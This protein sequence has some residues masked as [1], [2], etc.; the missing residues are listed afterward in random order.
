MKLSKILCYISFIVIAVF[1]MPAFAA[2]PIGQLDS[3]DDINDINAPFDPNTRWVDTGTTGLPTGRML[4]APPGEVNEGTGSMK[5]NFTP[6]ILNIHKQIEV[7]R[8]FSPVLDVNYQTQAITLWVWSAEV[9]DSRSQT[10][11][12][13]LQNVVLYDS[14]VGASQHIG[15]FTVPPLKYVG[16]NKVIAPFRN[17]MWTAGKGVG[18]PLIKPG[19]VEWNKITKIGLFVSC[20]PNYLIGNPIYMDNLRLELAP[21]P[22]AR[23]YQIASCDN[24]VNDLWDELRG[25]GVMVQSDA[26]FHEG[27][28]SMMIDF[29]VYG[30]AKPDIC[31]SLYF[32]PA[33]DFTNDYND[34]AITVWL[35]TDKV[36]DSKLKEIILHDAEWN[37][38]RFRVPLTLSPGWNKIV[39]RLDEFLWNRTGNDTTTI[40][41]NEVRK[42]AILSMEIWTECWDRGGN[43]IYLDDFRF[44][45][46]VKALSEARI[47]NAE[48][49][50]TPITVDGNPA[51]WA[52]LVDSDVVDFD[53]QAV[54][55]PNGNLHVKYRLAWDP[56][57]LYILVQEQPGDGIATEAANRADFDNPYLGAT[58]W[59][60]SLSLFFDF[61]NNRYPGIASHISF[62]LFLGLSSTG[63]TDLMYPLTNGRWSDEGGCDLAAIANGSVAT[64][65]TLG[66]RVI[67]A[68]IKW[69][70]LDSRIDNWRLPQ[71]GLAAAVTAK[72]GSGYIFGCDPRL[73]DTE[74]ELA[75][76]TTEKGVAWLSNGEPSGRDIYSIDV[77]LVCSA[78][79]LN[80]DCAVNFKDYAQFAE[81]WSNN[82]C[83]N[84]DDF[85]NGA[86]IVIDG[87]VNT[88]DLAKLAQEWLS[89]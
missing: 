21:A 32:I 63:R 26:N 23:P 50:F 19:V 61:T 40:S 5:I 49:T 10:G 82:G 77:R 71:G 41:P 17:F 74:D 30:T 57:Y 60:D 29:R 75:P 22:I 7:D 15:S 27:T 48:R 64:S 1:L 85:C 84:L 8:T 70:D 53:L 37:L 67:E 46:A 47:V 45:P 9:N 13:R 3:M 6:P 72:P 81:E 76:W 69:S 59:Y 18:A 34:W 28:G 31:P 25:S 86:D 89:E 62:Y 11:S 54:P 73:C 56:N 12:S 80:G 68:K 35:W 33:L 39:A 42:D 78:A 79:D 88:I 24:I 83:N 43:Q 65:G 51:D 87:T 14:T 2:T 4:Q 66:S 58:E 20:N 36:L 44:E 38:G 52:N 55:D 16:W